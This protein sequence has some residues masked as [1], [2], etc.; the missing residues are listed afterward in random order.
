MQHSEI[1]I[2]S[3]S[4]D[5]FCDQAALSDARFTDYRHELTPPRLTALPKLLEDRD[6]SL[7]SYEW[8]GRKNL[9]DCLPKPL[10]ALVQSESLEYASRRATAPETQLAGLAV[11]DSAPG[12]MGRLLSHKN[13]A[14]FGRRLEHGRRVDGMPR[15]RRVL[16]VVAARGL[17]DHLAGLDTDADRR[18][19][20]PYMRR[21]DGLRHRLLHLQSAQQGPL[22]IV[23]VGGCQTEDGQDGA[24][25]ILLDHATVALDEGFH[26]RKVRPLDIAHVLWIRGRIDGRK[27]D[28]VAEQGGN[29]PPPLTHVPERSV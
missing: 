29:E 1:V 7:P 4:R 18:R 5:E 17:R 19:R 3:H 12:E 28:E 11:A 22:G 20:S 24:P 16:P 15:D 21:M 23:L 27:A 25:S 13:L 6:F 26:L 14:G 8:R 9:V 2:R 10:R